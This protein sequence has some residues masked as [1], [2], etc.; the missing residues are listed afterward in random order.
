MSLNPL[1]WVTDA[2]GAVVGGIADGIFDSLAGALEEALVY[3][4]QQIA[5]SLAELSAPDFGSATFQALGGTFRWLALVTAT[6]TII[7]AA[8]GTLLNPRAELSD[9]VTEIPKTMLM[10][11]GWYVVVGMWFEIGRSLTAVFVDSSL[12]EALAAGLALDSGIAA[13]LRLAIAFVMVLFL[14]IFFIEML[15]LQHL[16]TFGAVVGPLAV[17]LRPWPALRNA[18]SQLI[19]FLAVLSLTPALTAA[20]MTLALGNLNE[21]GVLGFSK[22]LGGLAGMA[23]SVLMPV[24]AWKFLPLGVIADSSGRAMIGAAAATAGTVAVAGVAGP[25]AAGAG[26][27]LGAERLSSLSGAGGGQ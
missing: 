8:G 2:A 12:Q 17:A 21:A 5:S 6:L 19:R 15:V 4:T 9:V 24:F 11:G 14:M 26:G 25:A 27:A 13:F 7:A 23:M 22:A 18:S 1:D 10:L 16:M 20:S 3:I